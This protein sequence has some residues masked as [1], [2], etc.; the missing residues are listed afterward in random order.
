MAI[1]LILFRNADFFTVDRIAFGNL[2]L[3]L[4]DID[5]GNHFGNSMFNLDTRI[6]FYEIK[7]VVRGGKEFNG[8]C[9]DIFDIFH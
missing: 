2:D 6:N 5:T 4:H 1:N 7:F 9:A 8:T 3:R